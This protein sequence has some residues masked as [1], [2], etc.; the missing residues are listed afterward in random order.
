MRFG[1]GLRAERE[2]RGIALDD[3]A[4][5]TRVSVRNLQALEA[6][7]FAELPGGVFN[8]GFVRAYARYCGM[9]ED[10][11]VAGYADAM[12]QQGADPE[13]QAADWTTFAENV[14][15][16]REALRPQRRLRWAGVAAM[17]AA[18]VVLG[19]VVFGLLVRRGVVPAP[20]RL[21][22]LVQGERI[23]PVADGNRHV[24]VSTGAR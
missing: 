19:M 11:A 15:R 18:V 10:Q 16:N 5:A 6:E 2:L 1:D 7:R 9:D 22:R 14:K 24:A 8:R 13:Q 3:I 20:P 23:A 21:Q 4:V 17:V 12:R